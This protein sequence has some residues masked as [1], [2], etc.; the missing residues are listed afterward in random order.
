MCC[1]TDPKPPCKPDPRHAL[2]LYELGV[3]ASELLEL[4]SEKLI[5]NDDHRAT[6]A[7][8]LRLIAARDLEL[9]EPRHQW[10]ADHIVGTAPR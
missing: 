9:V 5:V 3:V 2:D 4:L 7:E 10:A 8:R 1:N 6:P